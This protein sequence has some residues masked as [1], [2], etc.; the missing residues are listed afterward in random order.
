MLHIS[1]GQD[2]EFTIEGRFR[3]GNVRPLAYEGKLTED[4]AGQQ[5]GGD[6]LLPVRVDAVNSDSPPVKDEQ[7]LAPLAGNEYPFE[8][9]TL[10][11]QTIPV[12]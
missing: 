9:L 1:A 7:H 2:A 3:E 8:F 4:C 6:Q 10:S 5:D 12:R 11:S